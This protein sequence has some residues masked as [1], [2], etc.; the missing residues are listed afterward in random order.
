MTVWNRLTTSPNTTAKRPFGR[1]A[2]CSRQQRETR[3]SGW[4]SWCCAETSEAGRRAPH[5]GSYTSAG[6]CWHSG[7]H[8][9]QRIQFTLLSMYALLYRTVIA[10]PWPPLTSVRGVSL[11]QKDKLCKI[12]VIPSVAQMEVLLSRVYVWIHYR[13]SLKHPSTLQKAK[14]LW[15]YCKMLLLMYF[16]IKCSTTKAL[17]PH[18]LF[19]QIK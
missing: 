1:S 13:R 18:W 10:E 2:G 7:L 15:F 8:R 9:D 16:C 17:K 6:P 14:R 19:T 4:P 5:S 11:V 3:W 12:I